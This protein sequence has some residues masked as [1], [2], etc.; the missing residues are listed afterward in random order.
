[1]RR[2]QVF[3]QNGSARVMAYTGFFHD[4][5]VLS[6]D[7]TFAIVEKNNGLIE[8]INSSLVQFEANPLDEE[9]QNGDV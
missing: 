1:M 2:I 7:D 6:N 8:I 4:W 3:K 9:E 5:V